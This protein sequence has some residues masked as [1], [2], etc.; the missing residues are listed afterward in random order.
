[1]L[2]AF[3]PV[4]LHERGG[5]HEEEGVTWEEP[6]LAPRGVAGAGRKRETNVTAAAAA[7]ATN[8]RARLNALCPAARARLV[9]RLLRCTPCSR[10]RCDPR[11]PSDNYGVEGLPEAHFF[12]RLP[13]QVR[14][15][16]DDGLDY[17]PVAALAK[18]VVVALLRPRKGQLLDLL[19]SERDARGFLQLG[20]PATNEA[21]RK[22]ETF[23]SLERNWRRPVHAPSSAR[24]RRL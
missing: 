13:H 19:R 21:S 16:V 2:L 24:R 7:K 17:P 10:N 22:E 6:H 3:S 12:D 8:F 5:R 15:H 1:M 18:L 4:E 11:P 14:I 9:P 23:V 20:E